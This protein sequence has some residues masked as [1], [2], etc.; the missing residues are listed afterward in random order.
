MGTRDGGM[1]LEYE[2]Y[3]DVFFL[4]DFFLN[5][6]SLFLTAAFLRKSARLMRLIFA[7]V[8][9]SFWNCFLVVFPVLTPTI[10][11]AATVFVVGSVMVKIAF[12]PQRM[13]MRAVAALLGAAA[14]VNGC[15]DFSK[16]HFYL[17]DWESLV[18]TGLLCLAG[19]R[20]L[21]ELLK[22]RGI[23]AERY[24][25]RLHYKGKTREFSGLADSGNRLHVPGTGMPVSV[26][27]YKDCTGFCESV[28]GGFYIPYRA[29]G[30]REGV[31]FAMLFEKMEIIKDGKIRIIEKPAVAI[32]KEPLSVKG[33]FSMILPEEYVLED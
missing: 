23:G 2:F 4:T 6:L 14:M 17:S 1:P 15:L 16:E 22:K 33:E 26:I 27:S 28:S 31:L 18:F 5:L 8:L 32:V 24:H 9:G 25:V 11:L 12:S 29:V 30:T 13:K 10:E 3:I 21:R 20:L 7:A 19:E